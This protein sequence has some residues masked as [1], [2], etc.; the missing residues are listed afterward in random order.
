MAGIF[1]RSTAWPP[2]LS[3]SA[4]VHE[5]ERVLRAPLSDNVTDKLPEV[6]DESENF[7]ADAGRCRSGKIPG[8]LS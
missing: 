5:G 4:T 2:M 1:L 8:F 3:S 6:N 7:R